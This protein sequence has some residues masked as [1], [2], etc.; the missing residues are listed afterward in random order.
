MTNAILTSSSSVKKGDLLG[1]VE[2]ILC[3][4]LRKLRTQARRHSD[5]IPNVLTINLVNFSV[6]EREKSIG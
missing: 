1:S 5:T 2:T 3:I 4:L 6:K